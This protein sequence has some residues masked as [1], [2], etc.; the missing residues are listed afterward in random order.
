MVGRAHSLF[1]A[2]QGMMETTN[3]LWGSTPMLLGEVALGHRAEHLLGGLGGGQAVGVGG[4]TVT[5]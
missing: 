2:M 1:L 3:I 5:S 4:V